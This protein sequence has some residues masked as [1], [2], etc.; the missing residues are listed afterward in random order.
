MNTYALRI[1][2]RTLRT[3]LQVFTGYLVT[4]NTLGGVDWRTGILAAGLAGALALLQGLVD[5]PEL[6]GIGPWAGILG[7]AIR[8]A[9]Q[10]A[11]ASVGANAILITDI[12]WPTVLSAAGLAAVTSVATSLIALPIGP[13]SVKGTPEIVGHHSRTAPFVA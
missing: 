9:A 11:L 4:A 7:R 8:T 6:P 10:T 3:M 2:D 5:L 1:L 13:A 12:P